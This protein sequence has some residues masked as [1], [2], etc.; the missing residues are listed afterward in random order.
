MGQFHVTL[1][2]SNPRLAQ[3]ASAAKLDGGPITMN[4]EFDGEARTVTGFVQSIESTANAM[5]KRWR[6]TIL[7]DHRHSDRVVSFPQAR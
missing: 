7:E 1:Y 5:P 4:G 3:I 2:V 6:I